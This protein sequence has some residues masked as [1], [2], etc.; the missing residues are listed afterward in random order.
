MKMTPEEWRFAQQ[1]IQAECP[2]LFRKGERTPG[3]RNDGNFYFECESGWHEPIR[4]CAQ[5]LE[6]IAK[7]MPEPKPGELDKRPRAE[8]IKEKFGGLRF[9]ILKPHARRFAKCVVRLGTVVT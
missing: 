2:T 4:E 6:A 8:Q 9:Y 3:H 7:K 5:K 1:M